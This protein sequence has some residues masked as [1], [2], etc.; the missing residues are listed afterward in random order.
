LGKIIGDY[1]EEN[2]LKKRFPCFLYWGGTFWKKFLP[3]PH[4]KNFLSIW[5][6]CTAQ[7]ATQQLTA[8][9]APYGF[10]FAFFSFLPKRKE[11]EKN[12]SPHPTSK[13]FSI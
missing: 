9:K 8:P 3:T 7:G 2:F 6:M 5:G 1:F 11:G 10:S 13:T 12:S 4:F